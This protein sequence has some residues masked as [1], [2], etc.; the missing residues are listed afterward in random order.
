M[1][2]SATV[3]SATAAKPDIELVV[4]DDCKPM[5][6]AKPPV[7]CAPSRIPKF[8]TPPI[9]PIDVPAGDRTA[10]ADIPVPGFHCHWLGPGK[11]YCHGGMD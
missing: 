11:R 9:M 6:E 10:P 7:E 5:P 8:F 2:A 1:A 4:A 3:A